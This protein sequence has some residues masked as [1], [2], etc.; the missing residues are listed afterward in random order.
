MLHGAQL[1]IAD[2]STMLDPAALADLLRRSGVTIMQATPTTWQLLVDDGWE[3]EPDLTALYGGEPMP[4]DLLDAMTVRCRSLWNLYGPT[5]TTVWATVHQVDGRVDPARRSVPVGRPIANVRCY[6]LDPR[7]RPVPL[8]VPG[9]L[10][11]GG[12]AWPAATWTGPSSRPSGSCPTRSSVSPGARMYRTGDLA[13]LLAD[14]ALDLLGRV[15]HQVKIRGHRIEL[16]EIEHTLSSHPTVRAAVV[17]TWEAG[18]RDVRLAA[19]YIPRRGRRRRRRRAARPTSA[20]S[21]PPT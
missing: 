11:I 7:G 20:G 9:E 8:G 21:C 4:P 18:P 1:V 13:R 6:V 3:G 17:T 10:Y 12:E 2:R 19:Y 5:E 15:D 14:G 16:G